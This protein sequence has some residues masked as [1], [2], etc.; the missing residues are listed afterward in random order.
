MHVLKLLRWRAR[1]K[2]PPSS[3]IIPEIV[4]LLIFVLQVNALTRVVAAEQSSPHQLLSH[5]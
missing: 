4:N 5:Q 1:V 3:N 2:R